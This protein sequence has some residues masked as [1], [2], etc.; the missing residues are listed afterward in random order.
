MEKGQ[1]L[2][3]LIS[4]EEGSSAEYLFIGLATDL[5]FHLSAS[6][7]DSSTKDSSDTNGNIWQENEVT[8]RTGDIQFG[9]LVSTGTDTAAKKFKDIIDGVND[10]V[11]YWKIAAVSGA[12]NRVVGKTICSGEGKISNCTADAQVGQ[13][14]TYSGTLNIYGPVTVGND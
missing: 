6:L 5:T 8:A 1:H 3:L 9:G 14:A 13:R 4:A 10:D 12:N 2:R 11:V 7:E